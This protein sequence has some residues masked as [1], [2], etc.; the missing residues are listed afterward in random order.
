MRQTIGIHDE[1]VLGKAYDARLMKRLLKYLRPYRWKVVF[2]VILLLIV[3]ALQLSGPIL[4]QIAI[5][6]YIAKDDIPGLA[7]IA[8]IYASI[9][10]TAFGLAYLQFYIM[11]WIGQQVMYD[12]RMQVFKHLQRMHLKFFDKNPVGRLVTRVTNDINVLNEMFSSGVV[13][14]F[15]DILALAGIVIAML[16]YSW[17]LALITFAV[18]PLLIL[19]TAVFR[20]KAREAYRDVRVRLARINAFIQEHITGISVVQLF[21]Q[22]KRVF[23]NFD[24]IN[25]NLKRA[26]F[27]SVYCYAFFFPIVEIIETAAVALLIY[28]GG[29]RI[30]GDFLTF[31]EL[32]A[33]IQLTERFFRP[34]RDL[35]E[36]YNIL[37]SSMASSERIFQLL[38]SEPEIVAPSKVK[39]IKQFKGAIALENLTFAYNEPEWVLKNVSF[40]VKPGEKIAIVGS[41]GAGKTSIISLLLRFYDF[42]QG[43]IKLDGISVKDMDPEYVRDFMALVL[44]DVFVFSGDFTGNIDLN[45][46][47][48]TPEQVREAARQVGIA[49]FI[50]RQ[51]DGFATEVHERGA[52]LSTGQ[53]QLLSFARALAYDPKILILDEAT[54]SVDTETEL[55]IQKALDKLMQSRTSII[56]AHRLSTIEKADRILVM[57]KGELREFGTHQELLASKGIYY[58]LYQTQFANLVN[59]PTGAPHA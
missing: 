23:N 50:E 36:K 40:D 28:F 15:G 7:R 12:I 55:L 13:A 9:L 17:Q 47:E 1:E 24:G 45:N 16:Y 56:I 5:D 21:N 2:A 31:G 19:A 41:T 11:Q 53:K 29:V 20:K 4:V 18:L 37:Q 42:Q 49:D 26:H 35:S 39:T 3:T 46:K 48:I 10:I 59:T 33:F 30:S 43:D 51:P 14:I 34:L 57:H 38:D 32:V 52:T 22:E 27:R 6:D 44:Q 8:L 54:S 25:D 58:A